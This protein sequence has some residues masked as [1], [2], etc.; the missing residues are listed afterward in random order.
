MTKYIILLAE[1]SSVVVWRGGV[2][3]LQNSRCE[4]SGSSTTIKVILSTYDMHR[5]V[6]FNSEDT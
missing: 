2:C 1:A 6:L 5:E 4:Q 3:P